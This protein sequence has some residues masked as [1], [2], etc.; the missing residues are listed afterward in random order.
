MVTFR[1]HQEKA[2]NDLRPGSILVGGTGSGKSRTSLGYFIRKECYGNKGC[3]KIEEP[4]DLLIITTAQKRDLKEW[5]DECAVFGLSQNEEESFYGIK[6]KIDSWQNI[7]K[8]ITFHD[9]FVIFDEQKVVGSGAWVKAFYKIT[10]K[11]RWILLTATPGDT[12]SDYIPVFVANGY[13]RN[14][15]Q[16]MFEHA[17]YDRYSK[18][19]RVS[20]WLDEPKLEWLRK[21]VLVEMPFVKE[22]TMHHVTINVDHNKE[23][24]KKII[25]DRWNPYKNWPITSS[26]ELYALMRRATNTDPS[27]LE[28]MLDLISKHDRMIVFYS[29][30]YEI[31][32]LRT[33][34][35]KVSKDVV[36]AEWNGHVHEQIP[37]TDKW[38]YFV[39]YMAGA[40][41]WEC[42]ATDTVVFYSMQ[43]SYKIAVQSYGRIDRLNTKYKD[44]YC[45]WLKSKAYID[46]AIGRAMA[47]K[48]DFNERRNT[49]KF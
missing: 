39:N 7:K 4:K 12:W 11:N 41:G 10:T 21:R 8:Y 37:K 22:T 49:I 40:E 17:V 26:S 27:R 25:K 18:Y 6:V 47:Q 14:K 34:K 42:T 43:Y 38:V 30:D 31:E 1:P 15:T 16:F 23:L 28:A 46:V 19:P 35:E 9:G 33:L 48:K 3:T 44:L 36:F 13:Y 24:L 29:F 32:L 20:K 5:D 2:I 45:Y